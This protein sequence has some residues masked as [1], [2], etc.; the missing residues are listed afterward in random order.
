MSIT[1]IKRG[2][3]RRLRSRWELSH[4]PD[5][6]IVNRQGKWHSRTSLWAYKRPARRV[7][8]IANASRRANRSRG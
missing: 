3:A 7:R 1:V 6:R 4:A 2:K 8:A 5:K